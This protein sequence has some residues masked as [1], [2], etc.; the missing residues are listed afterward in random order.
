M[1]EA[2]RGLID[3]A[4]AG[5]RAAFGRLVAAVQDR[6]LAFAYGK[7][8]DVELARD[9]AQ[10]AVDALPEGQRLVVALHYLAD[11]SLEQIGE[12]LAIEPNAVKQRLH[13]ARKRLQQTA[14]EPRRTNAMETILR[15]A[16]ASSDATFSDTV[17]LFLATRSGDLELVRALLQRNPAL[18]DARECWS[19]N[20][21]EGCALPVATRASPLI[22][23]AELG[24]LAI[25]ELLLQS[26]ADIDGAC[27][28]RESPLW[29]AVVS[30]RVE[31][32]TRL[33]SHGADPNRAGASGIA[34]LHIA[35]MRGSEVLLELLLAHGAERE[36]TDPSGRTAAAWAQHKGHAALAARLGQLEGPVGTDP[37][38]RSAPLEERVWQSGIKA[39]DLLAPIAHGALVRVEGGAGVGRNVLLAELAHNAS[40]DPDAAVL[41]VSW[42]QE[43]WSGSE[44]EGLLSETALCGRVHVLRH[45][46]GED[47]RAGHMLAARWHS[48]MGCWQA[49]ARSI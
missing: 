15:S 24:Q 21:L 27:G 48:P 7:L 39:V 37:R 17:Q 46:H 3:Q 44:L 31:V 49:A 10:D 43:R 40:S 8:G 12:L 45:A 34:P 38:P 29:A 18:V 33:L 47:A 6:A 4:R 26:G 19:A 14:A 20:E 13:A 16:R 28:T 30:N 36:Q 22:R 5:D 11:Q 35:A 25:V 1:D 23:A 2:L 42:E 41:W 32:A 9:A